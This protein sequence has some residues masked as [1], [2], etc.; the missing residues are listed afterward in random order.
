MR[1]SI[2]ADLVGALGKMGP[3]Y[4]LLGKRQ[5]LG[6]SGFGPW[7]LTQLGLTFV[8]QSVMT[9]LRRGLPLPFTNNLTLGSHLTAFVPLVGLSL[10]QTGGQLPISGPQQ[11]TGSVDATTN[12]GSPKTTNTGVAGDGKLYLKVSWRTLWLA[13]LAAALAGDISVQTSC[14]STTNVGAAQSLGNLTVTT[15]SYRLAIPLLTN[16]NNS[17]GLSGQFNP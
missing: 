4:N 6:L 17:N 7:Q 12:G 9:L 15:C 10:A 2:V 3:F 8:A 16:L 1:G 13:L 11:A 14:G 5:T